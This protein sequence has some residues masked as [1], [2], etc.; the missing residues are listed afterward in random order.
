[1]NIIQ[2]F[3][4]KNDCYKS[5]RKI[6]V[7]GLMLHSV[8]CPQP[9]AKVF[10]N[11]F[12]RSGY[13]ACVH[14]F[15]D[16]NNGDVYQTLPWNHRA[17]HAGGSANNTHIGVEMCEPLQIKYTSGSN[18]TCS[19]LAAARECARITYAVAVELFADLCR[20]YG[21]NPL[22]DGVIIS[23]Y[24]GYKRGIASGHGDPDH[25]WKG[26]GMEYTMDTFRRDVYNK[27]NAVPAQP[28]PETPA[29]PE[30][31]EE[32]E[33][34]QEKFNE[35]MNVYLESLKK[36]EPDNWSAPYRAWAEQNGYIIG[37]EHGN[38]N[39]KGHLTREELVTVLYRILNDK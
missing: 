28:I 13:E 1:M 29:A 14:A 21:L 19:N 27:M 12:N 10:A 9:S 32:E 2:Q 11:N 26:L 31:K 7:K 20:D 25:L 4:T 37:D 39:Y 18:F 38:K 15:I 34:T 8:G 5:G 6:T 22:Q 17:W 36:Q 3:V 30:I 33:M 24:E 35:M 23:H 16:G